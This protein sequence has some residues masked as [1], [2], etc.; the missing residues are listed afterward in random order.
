MPLA[1]ALIGEI[2]V[3]LNVDSKSSYKGKETDTEEENGKTYYNISH[4][5]EHILSIQ[6]MHLLLK[7]DSVHAA[8]DDKQLQ[9][10]N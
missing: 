10:I 1:K 8:H 6:G 3:S 9:R 4:V 2:P 7:K 5:A